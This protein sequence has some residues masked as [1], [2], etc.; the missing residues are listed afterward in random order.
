MKNDATTKV[1]YLTHELWRI[2]Y[3]LKSIFKQQ[4][5]SGKWWK[6]EARAESFFRFPARKCFVEDSVKFHE[7]KERIEKSINEQDK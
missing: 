2:I 5:Q 4:F 7:M 6:N 1:I 3:S